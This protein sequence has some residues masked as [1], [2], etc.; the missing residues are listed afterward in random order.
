MIIVPRERRV[1]VERVEFIF[2]L[3]SGNGPGLAV[4]DLAVLDFHPETKR[5]R[6]RSLHPGVTRAQVG[7]KDGLRAGVPHS[8]RRE[9]PPPTPPKWT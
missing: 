7:T 3:G 2:G 8:D 4:M 6:V 9:T 5:M 1:F